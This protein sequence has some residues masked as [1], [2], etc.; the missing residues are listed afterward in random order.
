MK[1]RLLK[2]AI[3]GAAASTLIFFLGQVMGSTVIAPY[4]LPPSAVYTEWL[5]LGA[6]PAGFIL[7]LFYGA[8]AAVVLVASVNSR[9]GRRHGVFLGGLLW[10]ALMTVIGPVI[11]WGLFGL[12][13]NRQYEPDLAVNGPLPYA[14]GTL[15]L[16]LL[17]GLC[18]AE[19]ARLWLR[20]PTHEPRIHTS[21]AQQLVAQ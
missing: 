5:G 19:L 4:D 6:Q 10:L 18:V 8:G 3:I 9:L 15:V 12:M 16:H 17:Y 13:A 1:A 21:P 14:L 11:G 20:Q 2:A 7:D